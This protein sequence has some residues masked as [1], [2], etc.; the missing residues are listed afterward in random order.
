MSG[1]S[2]WS[3]IKRKK[4]KTDQQRG[5]IFSKIAKV[6]MIAAKEGGGDPEHNLSLKMCLDQAKSANMPKENIKRAIACGTGKNESGQELSDIIYEVY[7]TDKIPLLVNVI[8]DNKNRTLSEIKQIANRNGGSIASQGSVMWLFEQK[9][10]IKIKSAVLK[11]SEKFGQP[12]KEELLDPESV[13]LKIMEIPNILDIESEYE[14]DIKE[15]NLSIYVDFTNL[16]L[17]LQK[18]KEMK[19][20]ILESGQHFINTQP[21]NLTEIQEEKISRLIEDLE[22]QQDTQQVWI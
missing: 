19:Y 20:I 21:Q 22:E 15:T 1:H 17:T 11:P 2:K 16:S 3:T 9:G 14:E 7:G 4:G 5:K 10:L 12:D 13:M 8:T 6:I 18:I